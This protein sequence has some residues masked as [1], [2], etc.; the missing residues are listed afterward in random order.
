[1]SV[2]TALDPGVARLVESHEPVVRFRALVD[3]LGVASDDRRVTDARRSIPSGRIVAALI[4][5]DPGDRSRSRPRH[6]Y[7]KWLGV[8]WR[9]V[10][11]MDL[12]VPAE[13]LDAAPVLEPVLRWLTGRNR[14]ASIPVIA[15][16]ARRCASQ[17][18]N[19]LAV[20]THFGFQ[21][22]L[23]V[24]ELAEALIRWQWPDGGWNCDTRPQATHSSVNE[25]LPALRGLARFARLTADDGVRT[26][27]ER[28]AEFLLRHRVAWSEHSDQPIHAIVVKLHY[29]PYWHYDVL[30]GLRVLAESG[31]VGDPRA[32]DALDLL[33]AKR[34]PDGTWHA[35]GAHHRP[36]RKSD[37]LVDVV[38]WRA[39]DARDAITLSALLAL[40]AAGR[41]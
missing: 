29:P 16:R 26:A 41:V 10:S 33:E 38:D 22:D 31:H 9:L 13:A 36:R 14:L 28:A 35:D 2:V 7:S 21:D 34:R 37:S 20:A 12:G 3:L 39:D 30:A 25:T 6:P 15:G 23:R 18:G 27:V 8:H 24:V 19:A 11:L 5:G 32:I 4:A 40:K 17:E 1:M